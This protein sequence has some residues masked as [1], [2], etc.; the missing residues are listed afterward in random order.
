[1]TIDSNDYHIHLDLVGGIAGDMFIAAMLDLHGNLTDEVFAAIASVIPTDVGKP[2]LTKGTNNSISGLHFGLNLTDQ[3]L[4]SSHTGDLG[5][6]QNSHQR[7]HL[8]DHHQTHHTT[9]KYLCQLIE[10]S[11]LT[12]NRK[13]VAIALLS[14]VAKAEAKIHNKTLDEV[15]FHELADWDS[16]M[17]MIASAVILDELS[18]STWSLSKLPLGGGKIRCQH[19]LIPIPAP[20]T[21]DILTGFEFFDD[22]IE[23]ERITPTGAAILRYLLDSGRL[24]EKRPDAKL[25]GTGYG[26]GSKVFPDLPNILRA[27]SFHGMSK[28]TQKHESICI[29]EFDIDDMTGE[30]LAYSGDLIRQFQG[31]IDL[32]TYTASGKKNRKVESFR[33]LAEP[34][35]FQ[36]V[37]DYCFLQTSTIGLRYRIDNRIVLPRTL[38]EL[39]GL[40]CKKV[41]RPNNTDTTKVEHDA[42]KKGSTLEQRRKLK[43]HIEF[44]R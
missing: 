3:D 35:Q 26:L 31:V 18:K 17:D 32:V 5:D 27:M 39:D 11:P 6:H 40:A 9:Y 8:H 37:V 19:G 28:I 20:A 12:T 15:H 44:K 2:E 22:G 16:L 41:T 34:E 38:Q 24:V 7:N 14:I 42:L 43:S 33:I 36:Q 30:E 23:G 13:C 10:Q 25:M 1:M 4:S 29:I 21:A